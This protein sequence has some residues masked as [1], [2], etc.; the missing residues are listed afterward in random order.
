[1]ELSYEK[2][3]LSVK[4]YVEF[5]YN[6]YRY[7]ASTINNSD[8]IR[9]DFGLKTVY[10]KDHFEFVSNVHDLFRSGYLMREFNGHRWLWDIDVVYKMLKNKAAIILKVADIFNRDTSFSNVSEAYSRTEKWHDTNHRYISISFGYQLDPKP[11]H[12]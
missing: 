12:N 9:C 4:P 8:L 11:Q 5:T 2:Q 6:R 7:Q 3:S 10:T 1:M